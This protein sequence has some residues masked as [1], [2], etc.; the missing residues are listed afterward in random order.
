KGWY[1]KTRPLKFHNAD[2][3]WIGMSQY[4]FNCFI[5]YLA[6]RV[7]KTVDLF[8]RFHQSFLV[9]F[10]DIGDDC[11]NLVQRTSLLTRNRRGLSNKSNKP[12]YLYHFIQCRFKCL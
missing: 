2:I 12:L 11:C 1:F 5:E 4:A 7:H 3:G 6:L 8:L 10:G 9:W